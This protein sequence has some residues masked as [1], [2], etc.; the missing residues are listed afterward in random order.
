MQPSQIESSIQSAL[1]AVAQRKSVSTIYFVACGGSFAQ[2]HLP[3]Y[4]VDRNSSTIFA[5]TFNSAEFIARN[6]VHLGEGSVV[7]LCSSSGNTPETVAAAAFAKKKGAFTIGLTTK[8]ES[9][10]GQVSDSTVPY[11]STPLIGNQDAPSGII[12]RIAFGI[13]NARENSPKAAALLSALEKVGDIA[14]SAQKVHAED[15]REWGERNKR[16]PTIYTMASGSNWGVA[17]S[18]SICILQEMQ[19]I[20]SQAIHSGEY[21]HGPFEITDFDTPILLLV[22]LGPTREMD[23]RA[24][25]FAEKYSKNLLVLDAAKIDMHGVAPEVAEYIT[26]L[27]FQPLMRIYAVEL[28]ERRGH[29]LTVRRYMWKMEY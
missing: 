13:V 21:F 29:P 2:M 14:A 9:E 20:N 11:V 24:Q 22:G 6:P 28:A 5:E 23:T 1:A 25:K 16:E 19:W 12:L 17:Y 15:A 3:K 7:I 4:A 26:P 10:L 18:F 8:P 27:V